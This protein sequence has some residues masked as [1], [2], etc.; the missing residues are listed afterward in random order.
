MDHARRQQIGGA[1]ALGTAA[2][3][4]FG[5]VL[6]AT[7]LSDYTTGD[8]TPGESVAFLVEH[9]T[10][11]LVWNLVILLAFGIVLVPLVLALH[12]RLAPSAPGLA[13]VAAAFGLIWSGLVIAAG[14]IANVGIGTIAD[15][16]DADPAQAAPVWSTLDSVQNGLGG[17]N[18]VVGGLWVLLISAAGLHTTV[19]PRALNLLGLAAGAA[20]VATVVP[21]LEA[22]GALFGLG[23]IV[24]FT[25]VGTVMLRGARPGARPS[26]GRIEGD[27]EARPGAVGA[28]HRDRRAQA[29][30]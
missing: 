14:M 11:L 12:D 21:A 19:L 23:L 22:A 20:G 24:W 2:T 10:A 30:G 15:L 27:A 7:L 25:W 16:H 13:A 8:P 5:F 6:F 3:F 29:I 17:G 28:A 4:V 9:Q 1:A 26:G 18:E